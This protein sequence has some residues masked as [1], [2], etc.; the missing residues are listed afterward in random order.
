MQPFERGAQL[1]GRDTIVKVWFANNTPFARLL[2]GRI[3]VQRADGTIKTY[4][5]QKMIVISR[6]P[7]IGS[8]LRGHRRTSQLLNK[9]A[10]QSGMVRRKK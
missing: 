1:P 5:P 6:N 4:R 3:A 7:K 2:D 10:K 9:I 8:L